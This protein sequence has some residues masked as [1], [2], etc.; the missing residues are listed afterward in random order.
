MN[1]DEAYRRAEA[2]FRPSRQRPSTTPNSVPC[3]KRLRGCGRS[4]WLAMPLIRAAW[5]N[6]TR[7]GERQQRAHHINVHGN[8]RFVVTT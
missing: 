2:L 4:G 5:H 6:R 7:H 1:S 8:R 3:E